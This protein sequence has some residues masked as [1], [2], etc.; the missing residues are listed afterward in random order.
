M[1]R[2]IVMSER[3]RS[4]SDPLVSALFLFQYHQCHYATTATAHR[5]G[6]RAVR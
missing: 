3:S 2:K 5:S 6:E 4:A 1:K